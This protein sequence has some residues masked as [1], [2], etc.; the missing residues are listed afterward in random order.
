MSTFDAILQSR[1]LSA[2]D[3]RPLWAYEI[4]AEEYCIL[5][6]ELRTSRSLAWLPVECALY[7]SEWWRQEYSGGHYSWVSILL[8]L[9]TDNFT[10]EEFCDA[11]LLGARRLGLCWLKTDS[12]TQYLRTLLLQGGLPLQRLLQ[13]EG[14]V[15]IRFM[16]ALLK[17]RKIHGDDSYTA[18]EIME[19]ENDTPLSILPQTYRTYEIVELSLATVHAVLRRDMDSL[20]F[21]QGVGEQLLHCLAAVRD[22]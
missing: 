2:H 9:C 4:T 19:D 15:F 13:I 20:P 11:A 14:G 5:K 6:Q 16:T 8:T 18:E 22:N 3:G 21:P 7:I 10:K 17:Q 1:G 12:T